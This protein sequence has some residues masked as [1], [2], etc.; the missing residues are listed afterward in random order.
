MCWRL[1]AWHNGGLYDGMGGWRAGW[2]MS[3]A[4]HQEAKQQYKIFREDLLWCVSLHYN[5]MVI[6]SVLYAHNINY[7]ENNVQLDPIIT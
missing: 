7:I 6:E 3:E 1:Q 5:D 2:L 4:F